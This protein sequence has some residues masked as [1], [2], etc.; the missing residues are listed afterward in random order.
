MRNLSSPSIMWFKAVLFV[1][2]GLMGALVIL[3]EHPHVRT[4]ALLAITVWCFAR[5][6]YF[7]FYVL[8]RYVDRAGAVAPFDPSRHDLAERMDRRATP[9]TLRTKNRKSSL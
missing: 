1:T 5:A 3:L 4:A 9:F 7:A 6:Y 8:E 2:A